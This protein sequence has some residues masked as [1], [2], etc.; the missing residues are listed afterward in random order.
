MNADGRL[1]ATQLSGR[2]AWDGQDDPLVCVA[3]EDETPDVKTFRFEARSGRPFSFHAGQFVTLSIPVGGATASRCFTIASSPARAA[4]IA[5]T[6]KA[7]GPGGAT[8]WLHD[9]VTPGSIVEARRATGLFRIE[10]EPREPLVLVSAGSGA[11]PMMAM[12]RWL[13][14]LGCDAEVHYIH[15]GKSQADLLFKREVEAIA[16]RRP[17]L[18]LHWFTTREGSARPDAGTI[19][20]LVPSLASARTFVCG[21]D[22]FMAALAEAFGRAGGAADRF[23]QESFVEDMAAAPLPASAGSAGHPVRVQPH[24]TVVEAHPDET[25]LVAL[26][27]A[28]IAVPSSCR[29]GLCATCRIRLVSGDVLMKQDGGLFDDEVEAGDRLA[30]CSYALGPLEIRIA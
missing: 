2:D 20:A 12:L 21:P 19:A 7:H 8:R 25:L 24:G 18:M 29:K 16:A 14:D 4:Q 9:S 30:C 28:G 27:R 13:D 1:G 26:T 11:T 5:L 22:A 15:I 3:V 6:I 23:H 17:K 10:Q